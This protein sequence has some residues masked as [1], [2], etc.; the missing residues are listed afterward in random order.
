M[1]SEPA[2]IRLA[3]EAEELRNRPATLE[4]LKMKDEMKDATFAPSIPTN[5]EIKIAYSGEK[6]NVVRRLSTS[7]LENS[8]FKKLS[9]LKEE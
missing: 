9:K 4:W 6:K 7:R 8:E 2:Y 1:N 3:R 5:P